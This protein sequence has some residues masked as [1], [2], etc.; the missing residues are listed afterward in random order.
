M[1]LSN[2]T[3]TNGI[4]Y[5]NAKLLITIFLILNNIYYININKNTL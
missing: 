1:Y 2:K 3:K 4:S 5:F